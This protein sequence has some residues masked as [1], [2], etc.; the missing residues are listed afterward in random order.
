[1]YN[2]RS[3]YIEADPG[4]C[5]ID[6]L[7]RDYGV[8]L[9]LDVREIICTEVFMSSTIV[10][11]PNSQIRQ[12]AE[13]LS[14]AFCIDPIVSHFFPE[15]ATAKQQALHQVS[16]CLLSY[17]AIYQHIYTTADL[18]KGIAMWLPP[19][20]SSFQLSKLCHL[21]QSGLLSLPFYARRNRV[22]DFTGF[23]AEEIQQHQQITEPFWYLLM[24]G[25]APGYQNQGI[26]KALLQPILERADRD[27]TLCYLETS[28]EAAL[29]FYQRQGFEVV[30]TGQ[31]TKSLSY[32]N[33][34]RHPK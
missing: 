22:I 34:K 26:G 28:T 29:R 1:M 15:E 10:Q 9:L 21:L 27:R 24:L 25:V 16:Q 11:L 32:W 30:H 13:I 12:A 31:V 4:N 23:L 6:R 18:P 2:E 14:A 3:I 20:A 19:K 5:G 7:I 17:S 8:V 33:L